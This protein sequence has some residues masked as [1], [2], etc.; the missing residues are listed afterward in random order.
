MIDITTTTR[1]KAIKSIKDEINNI[2]THHLAFLSFEVNGASKIKKKNRQLLIDEI[3]N[4]LEKS[5][6]ET[7]KFFYFSVFGSGITI[8]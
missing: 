2:P 3:L 6:N 8:V 5:E 7:I 1:N 4:F